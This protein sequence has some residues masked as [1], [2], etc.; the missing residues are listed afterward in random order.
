MEEQKERERERGRGRAVKVVI[1]GSVRRIWQQRK[2]D[3]RYREW[4]SGDKY[5][6]SSLARP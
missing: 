5:Y 1:L 4:K 3:S 2:A 6:Q